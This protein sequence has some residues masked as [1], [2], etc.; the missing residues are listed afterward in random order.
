MLHKNHFL[1]GISSGYDKISYH[2]EP[3][4]IIMPG[5]TG[6]CLGFDCCT[7]NYQRKTVTATRTEIL[8]YSSTKPGFGLVVCARGFDSIK[9][10]VEIETAKSN[11][12]LQL[13]GSY[14]QG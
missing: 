14:G 11:K 7:E 3:Q 12:L 1:S 4:S 10:N 9:S 6:E 13:L 2:D 5:I 8:F